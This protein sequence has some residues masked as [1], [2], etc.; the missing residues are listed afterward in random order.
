MPSLSLK[1]QI[2]EQAQLREN[3]VPLQV[4]ALWTRI[5]KKLNAV[6]ALRELV[7]MVEAA[8]SKSPLFDLCPSEKEGLKKWRES[9]MMR[10][11][12]DPHDSDGIEAESHLTPGNYLWLCKNRSPTVSLLVHVDRRICPFAMS[13]L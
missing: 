13:L 10:L 9:L 2:Q 4:V 7:R 8:T 1:Q 3:K 12:R 5:L 6:R 11:P